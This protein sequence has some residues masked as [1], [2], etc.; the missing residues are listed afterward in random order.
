MPRIAAA[1]AT[2][3]AKPGFCPMATQVELAHEDSVAAFYKIQNCDENGEYRANM[4]AAAPT[5]WHGRRAA[6]TSWL[7]HFGTRAPLAAPRWSGRATTGFWAPS[8]G[9]V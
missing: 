9:S 4:R 5:R 1:G 8:W 2:G 6:S 7:A 3:G